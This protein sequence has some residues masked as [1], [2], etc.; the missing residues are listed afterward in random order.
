M[1][2]ALRA[3][4]KNIA[5][6]LIFII[7]IRLI[8]ADKSEKYIN[9]ASGLV[10]VLVACTPVFSF[11]SEGAGNIDTAVFQSLSDYDT[12]YEY[13]QTQENSYMKRI[14]TD[15]L[16]KSIADDVSGLGIKCE[17]V[18]VSIA[19]NFESTGGIEEITVF[20]DGEAENIAVA[21]E[22]IKERYGTENVFIKYR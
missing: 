14:Y 22:F 1:I 6:F 8:S 3:Y 16:K 4:I 20:I 9:F 18:E 12:D 19:D 2:E 7:V 21:E 13:Y 5:G 11:I 17:T 10:L 15:E